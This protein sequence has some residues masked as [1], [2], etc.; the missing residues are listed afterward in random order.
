[1]GSIC[2]DT[3]ERNDTYP[4]GEANEMGALGL[5]RL[6]IDFGWP[7]ER[8]CVVVSAFFYDSVMYVWLYLKV[9]CMCMFW[10]QLSCL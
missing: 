9:V 5:H 7:K 2:G 6:R 3:M 4:A 8:D 1:M 10:S